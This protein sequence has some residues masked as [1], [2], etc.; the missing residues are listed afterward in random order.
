MKR[1]NS[2]LSSVGFT[3]LEL[4]LIISMIGLT[5]LIG[6]PFLFGTLEKKRLLTET[7]KVA[8]ALKNAQQQSR[9][10]QDG[11][12]YGVRFS[13]DRLTT[14]PENQTL[15]LAHNI[16]LAQF[17]SPTIFFEKLTGFSDSE[18]S[19]NSLELKLVSHSFFTR[20]TV[21]AYGVIDSYSI[22][23]I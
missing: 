19:N 14:V 16:K 6:T 7:D 17:D 8:T 10:A 21:N 9:I 12:R 22:E 20:I 23:K 4:L 1:R 15:K 5:T 2:Y 13:P 3:V 11:K 18:N